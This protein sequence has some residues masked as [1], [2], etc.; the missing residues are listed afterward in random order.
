MAETYLPRPRG[1]TVRERERR[2]REAARELT[3]RGT[4]IAFVRSIFVPQDEIC[5]LV[6][7]AE[8]ADAV[9]AACARAAVRFERVVEAV[10]SRPQAGMGARQ[11]KGEGDGF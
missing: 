7:D 4:P 10:E 1:A 2:V 5:F 11:S 6:F 9:G 3:Q 8:S